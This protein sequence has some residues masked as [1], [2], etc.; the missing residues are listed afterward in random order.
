MFLV[1]W[2]LRL[3]F[4]GIPSFYDMIVYILQQTGST[5]MSQE[6]SKRLGSVGYN[7]NIPHL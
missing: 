7:S 3:F 4:I 2:I 5:W 1:V 6:V